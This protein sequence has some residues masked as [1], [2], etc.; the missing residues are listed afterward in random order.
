MSRRGE[1]SAML[2]Q[3]PMREEEVGVITHYWTELGV[4]GVHLSAAL[5]AGDHIHV[6]GHTSDFE[7]CVGSMEEDHHQILHAGAGEDVG[8]KMA[9]HAREHDRVYKLVPMDAGSEGSEL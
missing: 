8:V 9:D 6:L 7:Q 1:V 2:E 5:D 3:P 4:A